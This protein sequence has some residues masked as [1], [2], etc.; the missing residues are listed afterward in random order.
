MSSGLYQDHI[1][2]NVFLASVTATTLG[3][4]Y[5]VPADADVL[6]C[7]INLGTA[8]GA[9]DGVTLNI[10]NSPT[11][12]TGG[13]GTTVGAYNLW[14]A[15][16]APTILGTNTNNLMVSQSN[17]FY[18][19]S[20]L[21]KNQPYALNYPLPGPTGTVGYVTAQATSQTT[22]TPVTSPPTQYAFGLTGFGSVAPD[23]T[24]TDYN[25]NT[26]SPA[27]YVHA[28][29]VF[30]FVI[31]AAGSNVSVGAAANLNIEVVMAKR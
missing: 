17:V 29:D 10:N 26:L 24:Y 8:P 15:A 22:E 27:S 6:G 18:G 25:G 4:K 3:Q 5:V 20:L 11:S 30:S 2:A 7:I 13:G 9:T 28:G 14:T 19:T 1:I 31:T 16:N 21:V 23:N 12:Q